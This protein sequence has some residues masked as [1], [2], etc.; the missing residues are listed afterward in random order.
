VKKLQH[1]TVCVREMSFADKVGR[2]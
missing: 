2:F 1:I